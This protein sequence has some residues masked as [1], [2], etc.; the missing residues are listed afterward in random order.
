MKVFT[1]GKA[2]IFLTHTTL[3][4]F[5]QV[6]LLSSWRSVFLVFGFGF[7]LWVSGLVLYLFTEGGQVTA[8]TLLSFVLSNDPIN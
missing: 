6:F 8:F 5:S 4:Y 7:G 1:F 2:F 3:S